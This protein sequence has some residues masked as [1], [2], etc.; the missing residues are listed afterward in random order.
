MKN[1]IL[2]LSLL[3][4]ACSSSTV[5][6]S[7]DPDAR[8]FVNGEYMGTGRAYYSDQK[9]AF[10]KNNVELRKEGCP[11]QKHSFRRN[12]E[13]DVGAIVGGILFTFPYLWV[14]EYK[15]SRTYDD[16]CTTNSL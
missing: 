7:T 14:A 3:A 4:T 8:I 13:A 16:R 9:I 10:S 2:L 6:R 12:E 5:I 11:T 1:I 15:R